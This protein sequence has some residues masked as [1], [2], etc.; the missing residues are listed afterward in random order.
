MEYINVSPSDFIHF[1][2]SFL[3]LHLLA[4]YS[5]FLS[6]SLNLFLRHFSQPSTTLKHHELIPI[7]LAEVQLGSLVDVHMSDGHLPRTLS[8]MNPNP[9]LINLTPNFKNQTLNNISR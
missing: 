6:L 8:H 7:Y 3:S 4:L 1:S 9:S 2:L 5:L